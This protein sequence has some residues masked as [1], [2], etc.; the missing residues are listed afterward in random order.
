MVTFLFITGLIFFF[1]VLVGSIIAWSNKSLSGT[2]ALVYLF[3]VLLFF[4]A[5]VVAKHIGY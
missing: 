2:E 1:L 4:I 3:M 5:A